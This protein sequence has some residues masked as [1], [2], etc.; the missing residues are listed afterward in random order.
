MQHV[1]DVRI[2]AVR[3]LLTTL[4]SPDLT[5]TRVEINENLREGISSVLNSSCYFTWSIYHL[6]IGT[7]AEPPMTNMRPVCA[8]SY[9]VSPTCWAI[10][11]ALNQI[12]SEVQ[13]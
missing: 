12:A 9:S 5:W 4:G 8:A 7:D 3:T 11:S 6:Y 2:V 1:M 10:T 13:I